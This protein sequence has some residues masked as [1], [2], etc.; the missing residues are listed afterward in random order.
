MTTLELDEEC[1]IKTSIGS[2]TMLPAEVAHLM[3]ARTP[4]DGSVE[5]TEEVGV[6]EEVPV[7]NSLILP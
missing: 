6:E 7:A 4:S 1:T 2:R 3:E 5:G